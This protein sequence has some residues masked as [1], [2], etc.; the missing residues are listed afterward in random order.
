MT[1]I[2]FTTKLQLINEGWNAFIEGKS[3]RSNPYKKKNR[4]S[5]SDKNR[6]AEDLWDQGW[7]VGKEAKTFFG[8]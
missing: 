3:R 5:R 6:I 4:I 1:V 7:I 2:N 8:E